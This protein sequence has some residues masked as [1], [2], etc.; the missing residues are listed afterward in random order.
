MSHPSNPKG[1]KWS[2]YRDYGRF[3]PFT[4]VKIAGGETQAFRYRFRVTSG[5][6]PSREQLAHEYVGFSKED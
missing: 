2:A 4:V 6:A 3:G 1:A 5:E